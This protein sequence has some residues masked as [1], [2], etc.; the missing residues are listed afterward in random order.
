[1]LGESM[2][3][4]GIRVY[5]L[6]CPRPLQWSLSCQWRRPGKGRGTSAGAG[7]SRPPSPTPRPL[8][9]PPPGSVRLR[10]H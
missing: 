7:A 5:L 2:W 1:M 9:A 3:K 10:Y 4:P 6:V 8:P